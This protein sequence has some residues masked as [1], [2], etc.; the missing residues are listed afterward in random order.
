MPEKGISEYLSGIWLDQNGDVIQEISLPPIRRFTL[1]QEFISLRQA[2]DTA[3]N[4]GF[5]VRRTTAEL[6]YDGNIQ[7][8][9]YHLQQPTRSWNGA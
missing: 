3:A 2:Y 7:S 1:K 6:R 5:N 4:S 8:I 9:V